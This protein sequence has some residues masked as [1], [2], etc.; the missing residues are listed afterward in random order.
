[1]ISL[2]TLAIELRGY[3]PCLTSL[4]NCK[5]ESLV[6][7]LLYGPERGLLLCS[8]AT[9]LPTGIVCCDKHTH[10]VNRKCESAVGLWWGLASTLSPNS[11]GINSL[12][13]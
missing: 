3:R 10:T 5:G 12:H 1:M 7:R 2:E 11:A 13:L 9:V 8:A 6:L 4:L